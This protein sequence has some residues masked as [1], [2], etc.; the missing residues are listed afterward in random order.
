MDMRH[1]RSFLVMAEELHQGRAAARLG[2]EQPPLSRQ[3]K[4]LEEELGVQLFHRTTRATFL[5]EAGEALL[6]ATRRILADEQ[7]TRES[8]RAGWLASKRLRIGVSEGFVGAPLGRCC[9][10]SR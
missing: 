10:I 7:L 4:E 9:A 6:P 3:I 5:S 1:L 8:V 2:I